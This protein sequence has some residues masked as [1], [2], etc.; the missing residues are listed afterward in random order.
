MPWSKKI[1]LFVALSFNFLHPFAQAQDF[2]SR[3]VR[4]VATFTP[5]GAADATARL[6]AEKLS[7]LWKQPV[8][9]ENRVGG[10]GS[11]G[12]EF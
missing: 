5:G 1:L 11:I 10:G 7:A 12:A 9:V 4:I 3:P 8:T 2:P 6:F